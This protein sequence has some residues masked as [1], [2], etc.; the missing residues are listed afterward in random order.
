MTAI[1]IEKVV[2]LQRR[3]TSDIIILH[4]RLPGA[5]WPYKQPVCLQFEAAKGTGKEYVKRHFPDVPKEF[6]GAYGG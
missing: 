4:T 2:V 1:G 5:T 3:H 6:I